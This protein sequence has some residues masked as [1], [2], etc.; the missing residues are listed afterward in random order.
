MYYIKKMICKN[1]MIPNKYKRR[2]IKVFWKLV[3]S[4]R[5][6]PFESV[7][8]R[9]KKVTLHELRRWNEQVNRNG[10]RLEKLKKMSLS[11]SKNLFA[12][13]VLVKH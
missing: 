12:S 7:K 2:V 4:V 6:R 9:F 10:T 13:F 8:H 3:D 1:D 11:W 5:P